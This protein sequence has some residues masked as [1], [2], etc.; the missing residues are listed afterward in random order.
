MEPKINNDGKF[1]EVCSPL[2]YFFWGVY[3]VSSFLHSETSL[4][5]QPPTTAELS[6]VH[7]FFCNRQTVIEPSIVPPRTIA[8][9]RQQNVIICQPSERNLLG[10]VFGGFMLRMGIVFQHS[11]FICC[12]LALSPLL[13][14]IPTAA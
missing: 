2:F 7:R 1:K 6:L 9:S 13:C 12:D 14:S 5:N 3:F 11:S 10:K 8:E 4:N